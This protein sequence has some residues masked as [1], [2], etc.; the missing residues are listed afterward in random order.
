MLNLTANHSDSLWYVCTHLLNS[1]NPLDIRIVCPPRPNA[2]RAWNR[3]GQ[4][5]CAIPGSAHTADELEL[6][7]GD[8]LIAKGLLPKNTRQ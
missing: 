8:C 7:C 3:P 1:G 6:V 2:R 4:L 5:L